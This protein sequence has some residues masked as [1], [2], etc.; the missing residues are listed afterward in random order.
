MKL[1]CTT[2]DENPFR[3]KGGFKMRNPIDVGLFRTSCRRAL[4]ATGICMIALALLTLEAAAGARP[5]TDFTSS[6]GT[7]CLKLDQSGNVVCSA[8]SYGGSPCDLFVPPQPNVAGWSDPKSLRFV[9]VDYAG[10]ADDVVGGAFGT[11]MDGHITELPLSDG[12]A[13]VAVLLHTQNALTWASSTSF[14]GPVLFGHELADV[15]AGADAAL[16]DSLLQL[17]FTN[18]APRAALPD[19]MQLIFCPEARQ[20]LDVFSF[21]ASADGS[22]RAAFGVADGT[23]GRCEV[24]QTG[25]IDVASI[26]NLQH[27]RVALDAFPAEKITI[28]A[29]GH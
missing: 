13:Q 9:L 11:T 22:L 4:Q 27:S 8:S 10:L 15:L 26:A 28:Q 24:V 3:L 23:P 21:R 6:Q 5:I 20:Q 25:L 2:T 29:T 1:G 18:T 17:S 19:L 12:R 16:G 7:Y 14:Q